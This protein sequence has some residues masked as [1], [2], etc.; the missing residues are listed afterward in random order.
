MG[1]TVDIAGAEDEGAAKL[2]GIA[3]KFVLVVAG[4]AGALAA[5][6]IVAA[7]EM[8]AWILLQMFPR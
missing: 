5:F 2:E 7:E 4:G 8:R 6:E 1:E 3:A